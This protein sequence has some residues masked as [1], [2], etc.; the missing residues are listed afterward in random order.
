MYG[1]TIESEFQITSGNRFRL[2]EDRQI[3]QQLENSTVSAQNGNRPF[4]S[5]LSTLAFWKHD[6]PMAVGGSMT[7]DQTLKTAH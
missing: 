1:G 6:A 3:R 5:F 4:S 2:I 7:T